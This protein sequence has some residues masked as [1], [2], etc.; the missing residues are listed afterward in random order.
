MIGISKE[1]RKI[2]KKNNITL[3]ELSE[4]TGLS[5]S[6][7][8][9]VERGLSSMTITSLKKIADALN[10]PM[11][12]FFDEESDLCFIRK[13][14]EQKFIRIERSNMQYKRLSGIFEGRKLEPILLVKKPNSGDT[15]EITHEG[16]EFHYVL[17]GE[18]VYTIEGKEYIL[19]EGES[20][21]FPSTLPHALSNNSDIELKVISV[22]TQLVF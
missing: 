16:E 22:I 3:K 13:K 10:V 14:S 6:F 20:I 8:S 9:Q 2:R 19:K 1:I 4:K 5:V 7:L 15:E 12:R 17:Q 11:K 21:H 18:A